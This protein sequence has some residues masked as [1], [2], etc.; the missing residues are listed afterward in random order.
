M[1]ERRIGLDLLELWEDRDAP[2][3]SSTLEEMLNDLRLTCEEVAEVVSFD[4]RTYRRIVLRDHSQFQALILCWRGGQRSPIHDHVG[5]SCAVKIL[6]GRA[7]ET[8]YGRTPCG[9]LAPMETMTLDADAVTLCDGGCIHQMGN[10][11]SRESELVTLHLY[12]PPPSGTRC[13]PLN[14]TTLADHDRLISEPAGT[15][16]FDVKH[17]SL[18]GS[19]QAETRRRPTWSR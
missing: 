16:R 2:I 10:L 7:T 8:R 11:E 18:S 9:L 19:L 12:S 6:Q 14:E 17:R 3:P 1:R 15:V 5:S 4:D 13:Y